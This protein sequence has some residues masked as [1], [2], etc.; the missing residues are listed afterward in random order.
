M[1]TSART[2]LVLSGGCL[3]GY[4]Q[5]GVLKALGAA[6]V[7]PDLVVGSSVG[8]VIGAL[9][10]AGRTVR[11]IEHAGEALPVSQLKRWAWSRHGLWTTAGL[12]AWLRH[13]M[14][15]HR[16]EHFPVRFAAVATDA[17]SGRIVVLQAGDACRAVCASS[18]MPGFFVPVMVRG[19]SCADACLVSPLPVR[20]AREL[21]AQTII[22]VDT[23]LDPH[24]ARAGG[25]V[26]RVLHPW[27]VM[28]RAL[29]SGEAR[30]ADVLIRPDLS[31]CHDRRSLV[32][33]GESAAIAAL[34]A[35]RFAERAGEERQLESA[36]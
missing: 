34:R 23:V 22:A 29:A 15:V 33:A 19:R 16:I 12:E 1:R 27:R 8:A 14:P 28:A 35:M 5:I 6:G 30:D 26:D 7:R 9:L 32:D 25:L 36:A 4:A 17:A 21:G 20:A 3:R 31:G 24:A 13:L 2:A 18:A 10:A 11:D